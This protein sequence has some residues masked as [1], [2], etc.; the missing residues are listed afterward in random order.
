[1]GGIDMQ[2]DSM[3]RLNSRKFWL[4]YKR[5]ITPEP[6][7]LA[8]VENERD[9]YFWKWI[10]RNYA[11][12]LKIKVYHLHNQ[13]LSGGKNELLKLA[14]NDVLCKEIVICVDSDYDY[15]LQN[16]KAK[17]IA[18]NRPFAFQ[19][20]A[21]SPENYTCLA[22]SLELICVQMTSC[23]NCSFSFSTFMREYSN[24]VYRLFLYSIF[25][26]K[27]RSKK[28]KNRGVKDTTFTRKELGEI[29][30]VEIK[31]PLENNGKDVLATLRTKVAEK[32]K[33]LM[34]LCKD[35]DLKKIENEVR[36]LGLDND[37]TYLFLKGK[38]VL[39]GVVFNLLEILT[40]DL[41]RAKVAEYERTCSDDNTLE[42]KLFEYAK[43]IRL[44]E[45]KSKDDFQKQSADE[46]YVAY[47]KSVL[48]SA[49]FDLESY[50]RANFNVEHL[51]C[52]LIRK[53]GN[54]VEEYTK[55]YR[56][57]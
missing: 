39:N 36:K 42:I 30:Q 48:S 46:R 16:E 25:F 6:D 31:V 50:L 21:Y 37:K 19:T 1:M 14:K 56:K 17:I 12:T 51:N 23:D 29:I 5:L 28:F 49:S 7:A 44:K 8:F 57:H 3:E 40:T 32:E 11:K 38:N 4:G 18:S 34:E 20:Y 15:L 45:L 55:E 26:E 35:R 41:I 9:T 2:I 24:I 52:E 53:I 54:D 33:S 10:F 27:S 47:L 22:E 13:K 43:T